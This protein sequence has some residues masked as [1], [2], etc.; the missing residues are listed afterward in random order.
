MKRLR[1]K[2]P[3]PLVAMLSGLMIWQL[4]ALLPVYAG[5]AEIRQVLAIGLLIIAAAI[6]LSAIISF[7][8][9]RTTIDPRYPHKCSTIV[10]GGIYAR[11]RNPMYLGLVLILISMIIWLGT[12]FGLVILA[13]FIL[14]M[15]H[16]QISA[17]EEIL[18]A[19]FG[20]DYPDYK[21][22]VRRWL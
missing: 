5:A 14:Y 21:A 18:A 8:R 7:R 2:I 9:A 13:A 3:P 1:L 17:E 10:T 12:P 11:T 20:D 4:H 22:R 15:K 16:F 19:R 6:D